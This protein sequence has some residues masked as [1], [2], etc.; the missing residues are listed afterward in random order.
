ML[1]S[2]TSETDERNGL[3]SLQ[4]KL[5][6]SGSVGEEGREGRNDE[7]KEGRESNWNSS[8]ATSPLLLST[9]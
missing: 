6:R 9:A 8:N 5:V 4:G 2:Q 3:P 1:Q 7:T